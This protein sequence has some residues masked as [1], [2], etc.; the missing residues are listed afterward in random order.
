[1]GATIQYAHDQGRRLATVT[2][3]RGETRSFLYDSQDDPLA[4]VTASA[5]GAITQAHASAYDEW[6]RI[7]QSIGAAAQAWNLAYDNLSNL[8]SVTDPPLG[9]G[10]GNQR[11]DGYDA[12]NRLTSQ[13]DPESHTIQYAYDLA[14][15][16]N[17]L[18]DGR[19]L[20][21]TRVVDGFGLTIQ[22][23]EVP[24]GARCLLVR[25]RRQ[26]HQAGGRRQRRRPIS[27]T[28]TRTGSYPGPIR[29]TRPRTPL[30]TWDGGAFGVGR[31]TSVAEQS[32]STSLA[33]DAQGRII[34]D[35]KSITGNGHTQAL[36]AQYGYD[37]N[38]KI[39]SI[40]YPSGDV[41]GFTRTTDGLV[42][43]VTETLA[44]HGAVNLATG[45][46]Y[47]PFGPLASLTF[48]N[49]LTLTQ[50][51][52]PGLSPHRQPPGLGRRRGARPGPGLAGGRAHRRAHRQRWH[53]PGGGLQL[54]AQRPDP[55]RERAVGIERLRL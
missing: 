49:G 39:T 34:T 13:T 16:L 35:A 38:G 6:G 26:S 48:G 22:E 20:A 37:A 50:A 9:G 31:L 11:L 18:T 29:A 44:G 3:V 41:V 52:D 30:F 24:F 28:T 4:L 2:D 33:Y 21:T 14:D 54:Y 40:T 7:L 25:S 1:M 32:G 46:A 23:T 51:W 36:T 47:E 45:V 55:G 15:N 10:A 19:G 53:G 8:T 5:A 43:A 17:Q 27:P 42:T 12:L